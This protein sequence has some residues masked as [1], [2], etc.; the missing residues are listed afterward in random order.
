MGNRI[1]R[2]RIT[3]R[4]SAADTRALKAGLI[5]DFKTIEERLLSYA[6]ASKAY[7]EKLGWMVYWVGGKQFA[8]EYMAGPNVKQPYTGRHL[9]SLKCD[10]ERILELRFEYPDSILPGYYSDGRTWISIDLDADVPAMLGRGLR[11]RPDGRRRHRPRRAPRPARPIPR[12][13]VPRE[14]RAHAGRVGAQ[15]L[16]LESL[17]YA[18]QFPMHILFKTT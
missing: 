4:G 5:M 14:A 17:A 8:C 12:R 16:L 1:I 10:P 15:K 18:A 6:G 9:L 2:G 3:T 11:G 7:H 13:V